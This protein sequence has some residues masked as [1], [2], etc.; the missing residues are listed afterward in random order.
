MSTRNVSVI[1]LL[2]ASLLAI[3]CTTAVDTLAPT[4]TQA[5]GATLTATP[6]Q[7]PSASFISD[8]AVGVAPVSVTFTDA[9]EGVI[10]EWR[11]DF[12]DGTSS[13]LQQPSHVYTAAGEYTVQLTVTGPGGSATATL[14]FP[15]A[16]SLTPTA[17]PTPSPTAAPVPTPEP[18]ATP[19]PTLVPTPAPSAT[20]AFRGL[21]PTAT[22]TARPPEAAYFAG[23]TIRM[24]VGFN[25]GG[26]TDATARYMASRWS[27]FIPGN[28]RI[29]V[30]N[31]TP[32]TTMRNFAWDAEPNGLIL[33]LGATPGI[34]QQFDS[35]A[36][37]DV[38]EVSFIGGSAGKE[39]F[40]ATWAEAL[41]NYGC[42]ANAFGLAGSNADVIPSPAD[43][44]NTAFLTSWLADK[45]SLPFRAISVASAGTASQLLM[46]E[47]GDINSWATST[48]WTQLPSTRP[49]WVAE[50]ILRPF[51]DLSFPGT[52]QSVNSEGA[53]TCPNVTG[54]ITG[55]DQ[56]EW[57]AFN[58]PRTF[59]SKNLWG[60]PGMDADVL[61]TLRKA[62][63]DAFSNPAFAAGLETTTGIP[64]VLTEGATGQR[65]LIEVTDAFIANKSR[66]EALQVELFDKYVR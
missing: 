47:R 16:V 66:Y 51:A 57:L 34:F 63:V 64:T 53:F 25:P 9:S 18:T 49:G 27:D 12:G 45:F 39:M 21:F 1:A 15:I 56:T 32:D 30:T 36:R 24:M 35:T 29:I 33:G 3:G 31:L 19:A 37:F 61:T 8:A 48:A 44:G 60:P 23:K 41:P 62:W 13:P 59:L 2:A 4:A 11:W 22:S 26:G 46:L 65:Q 58:G 6:I 28:P 5:P 14:P 40:W 55:A 54:S 43:M 10:T 42:I 17:V 20:V 7:A 50:G 52:T 38:R